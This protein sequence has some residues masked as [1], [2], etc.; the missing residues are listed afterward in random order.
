MNEYVSRYFSNLHI[1][2]MVHVYKV[3]ICF[4]YKASMYNRNIKNTVS[5]VENKY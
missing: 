3:Q 5:E 4:I 2:N 1:Y